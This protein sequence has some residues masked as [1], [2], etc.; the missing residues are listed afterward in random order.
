[1]SGDRGRPAIDMVIPDFLRHK[2]E[3]LGQVPFLG[4]LGF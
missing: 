2:G 1:M 3:E 4:L